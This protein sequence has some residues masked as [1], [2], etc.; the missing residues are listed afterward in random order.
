MRLSLTPKVLALVLVP[1]IFSTILLIVLGFRL[2]QS[3]AQADAERHAKEVRGQCNIV[4]D[5]VEIAVKGLVNLAITNDKQYLRSIR[6]CKQNLKAE[7]NRLSELVKQNPQQNECA[8]IIDLLSDRI[9]ERLQAAEKGGIPSK[10]QVKDLWQAANQI[11][12]ELRKLNL[13]EARAGAGDLLGEDKFRQDLKQLLIYGAALNFALAF[14][15]CIF[16]VKSVLRRLLYVQE[17]YKR[18][19]AQEKL[20]APAGGNDEIADID[21]G[22]HETATALAE[23]V[24][25][26]QAMFENA[27]DIICSL[28]RERR[29]LRVNRA[30][31]EVLGYEID[32]LRGHSVDEFLLEPGNQKVIESIKELISKG[33]S[34]KFESLMQCKS[35]SS[36]VF[37]WTA[38]WVEQDAALFCVLHDI[39]ELKRLERT[40]QDFVAMVS[41]DLRSPLAS[42]Q[43]TLELF[44]SSCFGPLP[45]QGM[46]AVEASLR[47]LFYLQQLVDQI[48]DIEKIESGRFELERSSKPVQ[49]VI[50][51]TAELVGDLAKRKQLEFI[52]CKSQAECLMDESK[53]IQVLVNLV[54]NA[55]K[56]SPPGTAITLDVVPYTGSCKVAEA[57]AE[58]AD[59][60]GES[61]KREY[62]EFRISDKGRGIPRGMEKLIFDRFQQVHVSDWKEKKGSGL[63]L[64]ICK[65]IV[66][67]HEGEIGVESREGEGSTFWFRIP[68]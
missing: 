17:N 3:E 55:I 64:A 53:I 37:L 42:V 4:L 35:G 28:D 52:C 8:K 58:K 13:Y 27:S 12:I 14:A 61:E 24:R 68:V 26:E 60:D 33:G 20:L 43:A 56:Y 11:K 62:L 22:L 31:T 7:E 15:L 51:R 34:A 25:K 46:N 50:D 59:K 2:K 32:E 47:S 19:A 39:T 10:E 1:L 36:A 18:L 16:A 45:K 54:S 57:S 49:E 29:F 30:C 67:A 41:H 63:G 21:R 65:L 6:D 5:Y 38:H 48:L 40:K 23:Y 66:E 44:E 9:Y